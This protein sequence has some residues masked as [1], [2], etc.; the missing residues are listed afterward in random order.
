LTSPGRFD[1]LY[2]RMARF[3]CFAEVEAAVEAA[4]EAEAEDE[5]E[6]EGEEEEPDRLSHRC[7]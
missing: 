2:A 4:A 1:T 6:D 3:H 5:D 7:M